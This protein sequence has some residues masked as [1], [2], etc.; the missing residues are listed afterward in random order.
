MEEINTK[1]EE[2][3]VD[4]TAIQILQW[5]KQYLTSAESKITEYDVKEIQKKLEKMATQAIKGE[6][7]NRNRYMVDLLQNEYERMEYASKKD[8]KMLKQQR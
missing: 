6:L 8:L 7:E 4:T 2:E 3:A 5:Q 1:K